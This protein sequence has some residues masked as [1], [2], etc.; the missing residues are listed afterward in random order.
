MYHWFGLV[1]GWFAA[2]RRIATQDFA[3]RAKAASW[4]MA[5]SF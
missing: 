5:W 4:R 1:H 3:E 2:G